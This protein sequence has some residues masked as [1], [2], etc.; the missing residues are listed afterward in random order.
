[1]FETFSAWHWVIIGLALLGLELTGTAGYLMW[2]G[3]SAL[4][5]ALISALLPISW[6]L[7]AI[8]FVGIALFTTWI[9]WRYQHRSDVKEDASSTLNKRMD[10]LIGQSV[11]LHEDI[12]VGNCRIK[13]GDTYWSAISDGKYSAGTR[14][15]IKDVDGT[16]LIL[17]KPTP[18][19]SAE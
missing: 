13:L 3:I 7:E 10:Q 1:M 19:E 15:I 8:C 2:M 12:N 5:V 17:A 9:W 16:K 6:Q 18:V 14:L 4:V 11:E